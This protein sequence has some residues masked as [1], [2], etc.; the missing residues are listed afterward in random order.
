MDDHGERNSA[1]GDDRYL[2]LTRCR[3]SASNQRS[4]ARDADSSMAA[5]HYDRL[6]SAPRASQR[7]FGDPMVAIATCRAL[8]EG[9]ED[10]PLLRQALAAR[11]IGV[12]LVVWDDPGVD[13]DRFDLTVIRSTWD[14][15][16][17]RDRFLGWAAA[18]PRVCTIRRPSWPGTATRPI[19]AIWPTPGSRRSRPVDRS[20]PGDYAAIEGR[21]RSDYRAQADGGAGSKGAGRFDPGGRELERGHGAS[22]PHCTRRDAR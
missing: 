2:T 8:P 19:C 6:V 22:E 14:Y 20:G 11:S 16:A 18:A 21:A 3:I 4:D 1:Q 15:T 12:R 17:D 7:Q 10:A 5:G 13:W 9:D